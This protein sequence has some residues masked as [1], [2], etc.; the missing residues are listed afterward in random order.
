MEREFEDDADVAEPQPEPEIPDTTET[1]EEPTKAEPTAAPFPG[2]D[3]IDED[4]SNEKQ[5]QQTG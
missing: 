5:D 1:P 4:T 2:Q 3:E